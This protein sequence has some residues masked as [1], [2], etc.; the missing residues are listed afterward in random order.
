MTDPDYDGK[1]AWWVAASLVWIV[2]ALVAVTALTNR[3]LA[4]FIYQGF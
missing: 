4:A 2:V 1:P 3:N